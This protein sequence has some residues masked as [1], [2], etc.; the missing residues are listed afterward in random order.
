MIGEDLVF[1]DIQRRHVC[2][3]EADGRDL[4]PVSHLQDLFR[5]L[6][7][8]Q[9]SGMSPHV[10]RDVHCQAARRREAEGL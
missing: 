9:D 3:Q 4:R 10:L 7:T 1:G 2:S 8:T 5:R 6:L